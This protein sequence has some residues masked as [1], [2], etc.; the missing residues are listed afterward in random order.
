MFDYGELPRELEI[1]L[2]TTIGAK[3]KELLDNTPVKEL[4]L[5]NMNGDIFPIFEK[6]RVIFNL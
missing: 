3:I 1:Q 4:G 5:L 6:P 2:A